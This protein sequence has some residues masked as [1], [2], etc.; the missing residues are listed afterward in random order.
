MIDLILDKAST[1]KGGG[2][3]A[4]QVE[5]AREPA[6]AADAFHTSPR[7]ERPEPQMTDVNDNAEMEQRLWKEIDKGRYGMLGVVGSPTQ[8]FQPM[9]AFAEPETGEI[10]FFTRKDTDLARSVTDGAD[11]MFVVQS[12]D[13]ELQ[14]CIGGRLEQRQDRD[15]I[16]KYWNA[17]VAA[18]YPNGKDDPQL[19]MLRLDARDAQVWLSE[20]GPVKFA[21][22]IAKANATHTQPDIGGRANLD[23]SSGTSSLQ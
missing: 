4:R 19:T 23:L 16:E 8:H 12:K 3:S 5:I 14:A 11:A 13:Q 9:T 22:E 2:R 1:V 18:W 6:H 15:R 10:W 7:S 21:W 20:A 17:V